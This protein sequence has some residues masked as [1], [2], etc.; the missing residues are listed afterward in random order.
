MYKYLILKSIADCYFGLKNIIAPLFRCEEE[1]F[2][3]DFYASKL[4]SLIF[5]FYLGHVCEFLSMFAEFAANFDRYLIISQK[6]L[7]YN[8][9]YFYRLL[10]IG[11]LL[12]AFSLYSYTIIEQQVVFVRDDNITMNGHYVLRYNRFHW[13]MTCKVLRLINLIARDGVLVALLLAVDVLTVIKLRQSMNSKRV[14]FQN[15]NEKFVGSILI[16][17]K[18]FILI[19]TRKWLMKITKNNIHALNY[20]FT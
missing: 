6:F 16:S 2:V 18:A 10:I 7:L 4:I 8:M 20:N 9:K 1:C 14:L 3:N 17:K 13:S 15:Q 11:S 5:Y 12:F 19:L